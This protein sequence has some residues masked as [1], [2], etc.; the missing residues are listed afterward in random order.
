M[1]LD[2]LKTKYLSNEKEINHDELE[3]KSESSELR[4]PVK[5]EAYSTPAKS[6]GDR[7]ENEF[8]AEQVNKLKDE[9]VT[10]LDIL[11]RKLGR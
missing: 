4:K 10:W 8:I 5:K 2:Y 9:L 1:T 6:E 11:Q 7:M 3:E